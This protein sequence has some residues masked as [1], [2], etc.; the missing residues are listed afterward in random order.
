MATNN[1]L[2]KQTFSELMSELKRLETSV[3]DA[4]LDD[5]DQVM[6][7]IE[8]AEKIIHE[9]STRLDQAEQRV[10]AQDE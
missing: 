3:D 1:P 7:D 6:K 9:L 2:K 4:E 10:A 8:S 5:L